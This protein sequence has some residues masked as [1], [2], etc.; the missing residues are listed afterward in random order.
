MASGGFS[1]SISL[2]EGALRKLRS[3]EAAMPALPEYS[4]LLSRAS[5]RRPKCGLALT[6]C[7]Y[8]GIQRRKFKTGSLPAET[9]SGEFVFCE[10]PIGGCACTPSAGFSNASALIGHL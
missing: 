6:I 9:L 10:P 5:R 2:G 1:G 7:L 3:I 4:G 8:S